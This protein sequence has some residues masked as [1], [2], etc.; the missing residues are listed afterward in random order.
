MRGKRARQLR[1]LSREVIVTGGA[2]A[3][4][5]GGIGYHAAA[6]RLYRVMK[7]DWKEGRRDGFAGILTGG[8]ARDR[9]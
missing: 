5:R 2:K 9:G 7:K 1:E 8:K 3:E 4:S 6:R